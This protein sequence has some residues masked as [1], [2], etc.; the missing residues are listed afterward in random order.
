MNKYIDFTTGNRCLDSAIENYL[1]YGFRPGSFVTSVLANDLY[2]SAAKADWNNKQIIAEL[3]C[4]VFH[5]MP[6]QSFGSYQ[7]VE[8]W[9]NDVGGIR[10]EWANK[11]RKLF[12]I[13]A[14]SGT[15]NEKM[16]QDPPF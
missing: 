10:T 6:E 2:R 5:N 16:Q 11:A 9:I 15:A 13:R 14:L 7:T 4:T 8:N 12:L 1:F 3:E